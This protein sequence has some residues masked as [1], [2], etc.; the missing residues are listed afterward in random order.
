MI[1]RWLLC[2]LVAAPALSGAD[3]TTDTMLE[4]L[5]DVGGLQEQIKALQKSLETKLADLGQTSADQARAAADQAA[6]TTA[7][8]GDRLQ[9]SIADQQDRQTKTLDAAAGLEAKLQTVSGDLSTM[10]EALNDLTASMSRLT[11]QVSDLSAAVKALPAPKVDAS[12][13]AALPAL[14]ATDL[15]NSAEG[16]YLGGKLDLA[17]T[18]YTEYV[19]KFGSTAQAPDAQYRI[20]W[21]HY[22][23]Q[24]WD[25][26]AKAF[27]LL[28]TTYPD[29]KKVPEALYYKGDCLGKLGR[30]PEAAE[31]EKNLRQRFPNDPFAKLSL[32]IKP[33]AHL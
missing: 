12:N 5:R 6:K 16:D 3:K 29:S 11:T 28:L 8:L 21:I 26:A 30:W 19:S 27:D 18:E 13:A 4:L 31:T 7:A 17:M 1:R 14:S 2:V 23:T 25:D 33:P 24:D 22:S 32:N 15:W 10:R 9:K 20:A